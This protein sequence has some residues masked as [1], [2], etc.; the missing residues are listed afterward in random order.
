MVDSLDRPPPRPSADR[1][2]VSMAA[3]LGSRLLAVVLTGTGDDGAIGVQVVSRH[4]GPAA[5]WQRCRRSPSA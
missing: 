1:L 3:V 5:T 4:G 2:L